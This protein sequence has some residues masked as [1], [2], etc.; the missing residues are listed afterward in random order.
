MAVAPMPIALGIANKV[1]EALAAGRPV[2]CTAAAAAGLGPRT[3]AVL[4]VAGGAAEFAA[5]V[6]G[7]L[8]DPVERRRMSEDGCRLIEEEWRWEPVLARMRAIVEEAAAGPAEPPAARIGG[9]PVV[10]RRDR[11]GAENGPL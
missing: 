8:A 4:R 5:A 10:V 1:L 3:A 9:S 11:R 6:A 2:V 7:L